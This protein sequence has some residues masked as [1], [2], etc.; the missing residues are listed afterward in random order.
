MKRGKKNPD[1]QIILIPHQYLLSRAEWLASGISK[2][3]QADL[4][5]IRHLKM[6]PILAFPMYN[7]MALFSILSRRKR[8]TVVLVFNFIVFPILHLLKRIGLVNFLVYDDADY[9]P[10][11]SRGVWRSLTSLLENM[12]VS[13]SDAVV[14]ASGILASLRKKRNRRVYVVENGVSGCLCGD[15]EI[16]SSTDRCNFVYVG[17]I[18]FRYAHLDVIIRAVRGSEVLGNANF[19]IIGSGS[20]LRNLMNLASNMN[21]IT[22]LYSKG[23]YE[24]ACILRKATF[25]LAPYNLKG[26]SFYGDPLKIKEYLAS[27]LCP[28]VSN[29]KSIIRFLNEMDCSYYV[30]RDPTDEEEVRSVLENAYRDCL[31]GREDI[32]GKMRLA[33][34]RV[35]DRYSWIKLSSRYVRVISELTMG[36]NGGGRGNG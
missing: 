22:F 31:C 36:I 17:N 29:V 25:G 8:Y 12:T 23:P 20:D 5:V 15:S 14:S 32:R 26:H 34:V 1:I 18:D 2:M 16:T 27:G 6:R 30:I 7:T 3:I 13:R 10:A 24:L 28:I 11:F 35:C 21:N 19:Y 9:L 33:S 4:I